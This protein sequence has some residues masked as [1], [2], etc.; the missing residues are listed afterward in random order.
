VEV[1]FFGGNF[2]GLSP[3]YIKAVLDEA[4]TFVQA[5]TVDGIRFSTRPDTIDRQRL[6]VIKAYP[7]SSVELGVQS[8][9][10]HIL[11]LA[12]RGHTA[13]DTRKA[14]GFLKQHNYTIGLQMMVGLP[15]D[16]AET[17]LAS[18][19][20]ISALQP[21]FVRIYPTVVLD[22]SLLARWFQTGKYKPLALDDCVDLVKKLYLYF[23]DKKIAVIRMGLQISE[24]DHRLTPILAGPYHPSF[25]HLVHSK[26][27]LELAVSAL[28]SKRDVFD[29]VTIKVHPHSVSK[30]RGLNNDNINILKNRFQIGSLNITSDPSLA[31]DQLILD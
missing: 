22:D 26:I 28:N 15:G 18:A 7:V 2:L 11:A 19:E 25:G 8:M 30:M 4:G 24:D 21:D 27:F 10:D 9:E 23:K 17:A 1:A 29:T 5:G 3:E 31:E 14:V 12:L 13:A 20:K 16:S 6:D